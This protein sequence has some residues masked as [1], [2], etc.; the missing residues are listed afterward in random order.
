MPPA[1]LVFKG[2][3]EARYEDRRVIISRGLHAER[4]PRDGEENSLISST[5]TTLAAA[6]ATGLM[7][8][9]PFAVVS[10]VLTTPDGT[11]ATGVEVVDT[12]TRM[13]EELLAR[14]VFLCAS[15]LESV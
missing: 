14:V 11:R 4:A 12:R 10:R 2:R 15:T 13:T 7:T 8:L 5:A 9:R 1:E 3:L 6:G